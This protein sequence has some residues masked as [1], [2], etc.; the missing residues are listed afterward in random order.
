MVIVTGASGFI[1]TKIV[2]ALG[3]T[4][5]LPIDRRQSNLPHAEAVDLTDPRSVNAF[6]AK[7]KGQAIS[8]VIHL[9]AITPFSG[10]A[11]PDY[12]LDRRMAES[13]VAI[14]NQLNV[15][16][17][18]YMSGWVVYDPNSAAPIAETAAT[19]PDTDYGKSKLATEQF[20]MQNLGTTKLVALR[21]A[22]VYGPGQVS[23]G[24][25]PNLVQQALA[26]GH[27]AISALTTRRDYLFIDD[28]VNCIQALTK[29]AFPE[30]T[31]LNIGSGRSVSVQEVA[32]AVIAACAARGSVVKMQVKEPLTE[33]SSPDNQLS[34]AK[35]Q[36]LGLL[37]QPTSFNRG[38]QEYIAW[39][40]NKN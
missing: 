18:L 27:I 2:A 25:I 17:L 38:I 37:T 7:H 16:H 19:Q 34:I 40:A 12:S 8:H 1:G 23:A 35:A 36:S 21:A 15:A 13:V 33:A 11:N 31:P 5:A 6:I 30:H 39:V 4:V 3:D 29:L 10:D 32:E 22:S 20:F 14:C 9:A 28:L 26:N 24:L